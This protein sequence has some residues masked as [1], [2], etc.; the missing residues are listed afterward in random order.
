M[1]G[2]RADALML[3]ALS[4]FLLLGAL[5]AFFSTIYFSNLSALEIRPSA[6]LA[7]L[8]LSPLL[9]ALPMG[10]GR[11]ALVG[12]AALLGL[13]RVAMGLAW[14]TPAYLYAAAVAAAGGMALLPA[15]AVE[16]RRRAGDA[17]LLRLACGVGLGVALDAGLL[18]LARSVD[19][20]V[21]RL[22]LLVT[23][24]AALGLLALASRP[25]DAPA[26]ER[27]GT[28]RR[29]L[30]A[31][32][33]LGAL[34]FLEHAV[35]GS[36]HHLARWNGLAVEPFTVAVALGALAPLLTLAA[37]WRPQ[38][39]TLGALNAVALAAILDHVFVHGPLL[40]LLVFVAQAALVYDAAALLPWLAEGGLR[41]AGLAFAAG[42]LVT[43]VLHFVFVFAYTFA[44]VPMGSLW[45]GSERV[46]VP[47]AF[48]LASLPALGALR[49]RTL[50]RPAPPGRT[51]T[52][53]A[54]VVP[55]LLVGAALAAPAAPVPA[56]REGELKVM[57]FNLHQGFSNAGVVDL[58]PLERVLQAE[59]PDL[60]MLQ[61]NDSPRIASANVDAVAYLAARLG[62]HVAYGPP[63]SKESF[64]VGVLSRHPILSWETVP[65]PSTKDNRYFVEAR[66]DVGGTEVWA[67]AVHLG[68]PAQDRMDENAVLLAR[69]ATREGPS[70]LAGDWNSCPRIVCP[71]YEGGPDDVYEKM[72]AQY[73]DAR[74]AAG[75]PENDD[76]SWTFEATNLTHRIDYVFVSPEFDVR[77]QYTVRTQDALDASDHLPV[78]AVLALKA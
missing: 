29:S 12:A 77:E 4:T 27:T 56:P 1:D 66:L 65:L 39:L 46:L 19:P 36:P 3:G 37:G 15:L 68:L 8:L 23:V 43:L 42:A 70:V 64:G 59:Q 73:A 32:V 45:K 40:P 69:A 7:L 10:R 11:G 16:T 30:A 57:T 67:Y 24:P 49:T 78:V 71:D 9:Y 52:W 60:V 21:G 25:D 31:G 76:A 34:V 20:T 13:G 75:H 5:R 17:G 44:Y 6:A 50:P 14:P 28:R 48:L 58:A 55:L 41:R 61:E 72:V 62:Y 74:V 38:R 63:T 35:L 54:L 47:L 22:G 51:V 26:R 53:G 18:A 33:A 2:R